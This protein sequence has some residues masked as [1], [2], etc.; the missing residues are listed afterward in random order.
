MADEVR[1]RRPFAVWRRRQTVV[2]RL[3][4]RKYTWSMRERWLAA[5]AQGAGAFGGG[6]G[7]ERAA[8]TADT[9]RGRKRNRRGSGSHKASDRR[10]MGTRIAAHDAPAKAEVGRDRP[11]TTS[12]SGGGV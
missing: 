4:V 10:K 11:D 7:T 12:G 6:A 8:E 2:V 9:T 1:A 5:G 3:A